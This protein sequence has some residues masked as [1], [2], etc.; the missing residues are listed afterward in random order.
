MTA[1]PAHQT[2][3]LDQV[4]SLVVF[5]LRQNF[6]DSFPYNGLLDA[7]TRVATPLYTQWHALLAKG[8]SKEEA[9]NLLVPVAEGAIAFMNDHFNDESGRTVACQKGC[10]HCCKGEKISLTWREAKSIAAVL[11]S[12]PD[13]V[14]QKVQ[15]QA[16]KGRTKNFKNG[17]GSPCALLVDD[18]CSVYDA[19]PMTCRGLFSSSLDDCLARY[20]NGTA[21]S[22]LL[23]PRAI[24]FSFE[25]IVGDYLEVYEMNTIM[26]FM[27]KKQQNLAKYVSGELPAPRGLLSRSV[28][29]KLVN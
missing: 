9:A 14:L 29:I 17:L 11:G 26:D 25:T 28:S 23:Y 13:E 3:S 5:A 27:L 6:G 7:A 18:V 16:K 8:M 12:M 20:K 2:R 4:I 10:G 24:E 22:E 15:R 19:R 21:I 1:N